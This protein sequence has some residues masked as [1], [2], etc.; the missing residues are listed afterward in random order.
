MKT[1]H[2]PRAKEALMKMMQSGEQPKKNWIDDGKEFEG[3]FKT[4][5]AT[6][7]I[8]CYHTKTAMKAAF[9]ERVIRSLKNIIYRHMEDSNTH[10]YITKLQS[11][12][13]QLK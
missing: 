6:L 1:K 2:A 12:V 11:F 10:R 7:G 3:A 5:C 4:F 13:M 8:V 9:A